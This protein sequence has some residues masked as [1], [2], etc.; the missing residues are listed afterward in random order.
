MIKKL[1]TYIYFLYNLIK[2]HLNRKIKF[3]T[4]LRCYGS[5][6]ISIKEK[7][8]LEIGDNFTLVSGRMINPLGRNIKSAFRIDNGADITIGN[9]V[10][11]SCVVL[12]AKKKITIGDNVKLGADVMIFDSDM[13][14]LDYRLRRD[15]RT[16]AVNGKILPIT[17]GNDVFI[18]AR[19]IIM[20]GVN[21]GERSIVAAGSVVTKS[22]PVDEIW[23]G[24]PAKFIKKL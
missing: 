21:I 1:N 2:F 22:I 14:S 20:K 19:S 5:V 12:W 17:I 4:K 23:G 8:F 9:N 10:G 7:A 15:Y 11:L 3:G 6:D 24:N 16:D 18:G 13:H